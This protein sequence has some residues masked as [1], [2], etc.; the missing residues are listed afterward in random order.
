[1]SVSRRGID[2]SL[3]S[4]YKT[5]EIKAG[6]LSGATYPADTLTD[7]RT[8]AQKPD[9]R[10]GMPVAVIA[11]ALHYGNG[12]NHP[13]PFI[14][15]ATAKHRKQWAAALVKLAA[16]GVPPVSAAQTVGQIMKEDIQDEIQAWPADN[17]PEW[18]A[19]KG[20]NHG[21]VLTGHLTRSVDSEV[22]E[23]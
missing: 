16:S 12:Q 17:S 18:A 7:A 6:I 10:A 1:M 23:K 2:K 22:N 4:K 5:L 14:S 11:K 15:Q 13:R 21:L 8:G 9:P 3:F 20:F 19:Y